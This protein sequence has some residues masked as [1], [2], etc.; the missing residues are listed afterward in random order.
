MTINSVHWTANSNEDFQFRVAMDFVVQ[1]EKKMDSEGI[2]QKELAKRL[3]VSVGRVSQVL[4]DPGRL[5][6]KSIV[7]YARAVG[8]KAAV[9]AYDDNDPL[10]IQGPVNSE[11]F[12]MCWNNFGRPR[13]VFDLED[14][15]AT[16]SWVLSIGDCFSDWQMEEPFAVMTCIVP[17]AGAPPL[18]SIT[19]S[20]REMP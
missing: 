20:Y 4:N 18:T 2:N 16:Y 10:N 13:T 6:W 14:S 5:N 15:R 1:L 17:S 7:D 11:I 19:H 3:Q 9:V 12:S 8:L